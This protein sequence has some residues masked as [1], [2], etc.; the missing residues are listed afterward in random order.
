MYYQYEKDGFVRIITGNENEMGSTVSQ[1]IAIRLEPNAKAPVRAT[2]GD[3][4]A[5]MFAYLG[6]S[7]T[8]DS[9]ITIAPGTLRIVDT[10]V[11]IKTPAGYG[12]F[13][14]PRSSMR[15]KGI[16]S[17]GVGLIDAGYRGTVKFVL[18]NHSQT[19]YVI[20]HGDKIGQLVIQKV[21]IV[22]FV[23]IWND[24]ERGTGGFGSTG[25]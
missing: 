11:G 19:P 24:T 15:A 13:I 18:Q 6:S 10:G 21:Q 1:G 8:S 16:S 12:G 23:D 17:N 3:A 4:G 7:E 22:E 9:C 5:D 20:N 25:K 14:M 2:E